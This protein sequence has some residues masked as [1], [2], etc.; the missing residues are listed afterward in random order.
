[1]HVNGQKGWSPVIVI[2]LHASAASTWNQDEVAFRHPSVFEAISPLQVWWRQQLRAARNAG[3]AKK[4]SRE[5]VADRDVMDEGA[6]QVPG[7]VSGWDGPQPQV[8]L[9]LQ[10]QKRVTSQ[11]E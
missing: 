7:F 5:V 4:R 10:K 2:Q 8:T 6:A 1:M 3:L 11:T 9:E